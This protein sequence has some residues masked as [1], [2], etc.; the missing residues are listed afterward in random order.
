MLLRRRSRSVTVVLSLT[1]L[2]LALAAC[3]SDSSAP[4]GEA[5]GSI[6]VGAAASLTAS[7][8]EIG[9]AFMAANASTTVNFRFGA[10]SE[11]VQGINEGAPV[12]VFASADTRNMDKLAAGAGVAGV[13]MS[14]A[15][16]E[17]QI[18]VGPGNPEGVAGL[19][20]LADPELLVVTCSPEVPIGAY[21]E[22]VLA[23][24]GVSV[25]PASLEESVKGIV[26]K[27]TL[28]EADAG[29]VYR[30]DVIAAGDAATGVDIPPDLNVRATYPI[31][32]TKEAAN[33]E[34]ATAFVDFV[35]SD[36][37]QRILERHG[38][39]AP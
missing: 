15:T 6:T 32:V 12:D 36:A 27:V 25:T 17:L 30:T 13:P 10:S 35:L 29:I 31:A 9:D 4:D 38:F 26:T 39:G 23:A 24:A 1:V 8:T 18:I 5:G 20:D 14:F 3:A 2:S 21:T 19:A 33:P 11:V 16:N 37:G 7:F 22:Q 34:L 28:G